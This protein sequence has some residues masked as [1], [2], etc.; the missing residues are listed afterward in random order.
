MYLR[1]IRRHK[2]AKL[3]ADSNPGRASLDVDAIQQT[4]VNTMHR[5]GENLPYAGSMTRWHCLNMVCSG[6]GHAIVK[7]RTSNIGQ[8]MWQAKLLGAV[9]TFEYLYILY[10]VFEYLSQ[11]GFRDEHTRHRPEQGPGTHRSKTGYLSQRIDNCISKMGNPALESTS[12]R[13]ASRC[14]VL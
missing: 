12:C 10:R 5:D 3:A 4:V 8:R 7:E 13:D 1:Y 14:R 11:T 9:L 6:Q 2:T